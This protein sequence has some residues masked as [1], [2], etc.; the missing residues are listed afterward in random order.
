MQDIILAL[1]NIGRNRRR[2]IVTVLA[3]ALSCG[4]LALFGGY[5]SWAF[6]A[7]EEQT[8]G[9]SGHIEIYREGYYDNGTGDPASYAL[10]NY[11][12]LKSMLQSDPVIGPRLDMVTGQLLFTGVVTSAPTHTT[13]TFFGM[14]VFPSE[15]EHLW[16]WNP[17]ELSPPIN[18]KINA[19][20]FAGPPELDDNDVEGGSMGSGLGRILHLDRPFEREAARPNA[21]QPSSESAPDLGAEV[22]MN[23][24]AEQAN[25]ARSS[26]GNRPTVELIIQPPQGGLPN[27]I[28]LGVRKLMP[29]ATKELE[30]QLVKLHVRHASELLFPGQPLHVTA[31][32]LLLKRSADT[33]VVAQRLQQL[34]AE[35]N[36]DL[37]L[38]TWKEIRPFYN[39]VHRMLGIIFVFMFCL[40]ATLMAFTIY[41]TQSAGIIERLREL[42]TLRALGV[43]RWGLWKTLEWEGFFLGLIGGVVGVLLAIGGDLLL[44]ALDVIYVPPGV[45]FYAKVEVL[46][47]RNP[48]VLLIAFAGSLICA[49]LSAAFPARRAA[50]TP[51]VKA[52]RQT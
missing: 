44:R 47:L 13:S 18:L 41:N 14:G 38:K 46:A 12:Q 42:G 52:L 45:S 27:I 20:L 5:V 15:D 49:L 16:R 9:I 50:F 48:K 24:L 43:N 2:S 23:F 6:R 39:Q 28:T 37:E 26:E 31:V 8:V 36:L 4:G 25:A 19:P 34:F 7:V 35:R 32:I 11:D 10:G 3:V 22:D 40:L 51:I 29:R 1:R 21:K 33:P 30:D 17:Y